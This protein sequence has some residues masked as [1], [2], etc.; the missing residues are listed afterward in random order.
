MNNVYSIPAN[1]PVGIRAVVALGKRV[2]PLWQRFLTR[3][4]KYLLIAQIESYGAHGE[5][6]A[7]IHYDHPVRFQGSGALIIRHYPK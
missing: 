7:G 3:W 4:R 2:H 5:L 1:A 6:H